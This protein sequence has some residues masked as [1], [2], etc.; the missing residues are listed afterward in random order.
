MRFMERDRLLLNWIN[1]HGF[2]SA[3]NI[4]SWMGVSMPFAYARIK[5]LLNGGY[6][7]RDRI[8][9]NS[10]RIHFLTKQGLQ[11]CNDELP[12]LKKV[13]LGTYHHDTILIDLS[14][15][16]EKETAGSFMPERRLK[17]L[18]GLSGVGT[19]GRVPDGVVD[20]ANG[21]KIAVELELSVKSKERLDKI[22]KDYA[23]NMDFHEIWYFVE[24]ISV[25]N[26]I[27]K[28]ADNNGVFNIQIKELRHD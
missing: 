1:G 12:A 11:A 6:L 20:L 19:K 28:A 24:N 21:K 16:I 3:E 18:K 15:Q 26:A 17:Q 10:S 9:H 2:A 8:L 14:L 27:Q 25:R 13:N 5:K 23:S 22:M 4:A 7:E